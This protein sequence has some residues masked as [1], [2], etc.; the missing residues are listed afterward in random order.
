[1]FGTDAGAHAAG[2]FSL[3]RLVQLDLSAPELLAAERVV[4]EGLQA[5][6]KQAIGVGAHGTIEFCGRGRRGWRRSLLSEGAM[7]G[8]HD[9]GEA[10]GRNTPELR[11]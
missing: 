11:I 5:F 9:D 10:E 2:F 6:G 3:D 8:D 1:L 4:A 7:I